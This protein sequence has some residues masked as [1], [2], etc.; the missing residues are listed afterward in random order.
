VAVVKEAF[1]GK[2]GII[3]V[4]NDTTTVIYHEN[5]TVLLYNKC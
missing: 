4:L 3:C 2:E 1:T 5:K